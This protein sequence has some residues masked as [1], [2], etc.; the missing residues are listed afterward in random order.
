MPE[1]MVTESII[2]D[3]LTA[4]KEADINDFKRDKRLTAIW[5]HCPKHVA[6]QY[7]LFIMDNLAEL[8]EYNYTNDKR[9]NPLLHEF[10]KYKFSTSTL[11]Y[12]GVMVNIIKLCKITLDGKRIVEIGG[13]Y[14]GQCMT[15][16]DIFK[17]KCYH[18]IDLPEVSDLQSRYLA[19]YK[20]V[21]CL[22]KASGEEYDLVISN[23]ALSEIKD[24]NDYI[25][26]VCMKSQS[27]FITCNTDFVTIPHAK[28]H[29]D[30]K[31]ERETNY[32]LTW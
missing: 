18:I 10:D 31:G 3:Y 30:M 20:G 6:W 5:E 14:G 9:G 17:P 16:M 23:Y 19:G 15:I 11:Q 13:G 8:L 1:W 4:C 7:Y 21:K 24:N 2:K 27:G 32:I 29:P 26:Q 28:R 12:I 22:T 25:D